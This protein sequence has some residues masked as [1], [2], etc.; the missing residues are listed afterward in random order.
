MAFN[1]LSIFAGPSPLPPQANTVT[2]TYAPI[3]FATGQS[4]V[5]TGQAL[6]AGGQ[7][8]LAQAQTGKLTPGEQATVDR[9]TKDL[10]NQAL[11][12]YAGM[13]INPNKSTSY[14]S[15]Q[16]DIDQRALVMTQQFIDLNFK[17]AFA[18]LTAGASFMGLGESA[19]SAATNDLLATAKMQMDADT[20]YSNLIGSTLQSVAKMAAV[21]G[22][23]G[24][25]APL[26]AAGDAAQDYFQDIND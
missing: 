10:E 20:A 19:E 9:Y 2:N 8:A 26:V 18:E 14:L 24:A 6:T 4:E 16:A 7:S 3:Q 1:P 25:A 12:T 13:G 22:T 23:G 11:T 17:E 21:V 5:A 15:T